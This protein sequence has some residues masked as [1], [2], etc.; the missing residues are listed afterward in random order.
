MN[1]ETEEKARL[2]A[3]LDAL[4]KRTAALEARVEDLS[5]GL[6]IHAQDY[7]EHLTATYQHIAEIHDLLM[8]VVHKVFP[9]F[10]AARKQISAFMRGRED[11]K[12]S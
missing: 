5:K 1:A 7:D 11:K 9:G 12:D 3:E 10:A 8:P 4:R 2:E 6:A